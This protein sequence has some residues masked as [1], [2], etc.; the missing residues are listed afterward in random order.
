MPLKSP[1]FFIFLLQRSSFIS[2]TKPVSFPARVFINQQEIMYVMQLPSA[3]WVCRSE[4]QLR[5]ACLFSPAR[6]WPS[7]II[8]Y[9]PFVWSSTS[10]QSHLFT[11]RRR[12]SCHKH[13]WCQRGEGSD[14]E[15]PLPPTATIIVVGCDFYAYV[16]NAQG[17]LS[18]LWLQQATE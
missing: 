11:C 9:F 2:P 4:G 14:L 6:W 8:S 13:Q 18:N 10:A 16:I 7:F 12:Q 3:Y 15:K 17:I 1:F 5:S